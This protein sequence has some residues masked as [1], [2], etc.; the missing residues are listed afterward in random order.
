MFRLSVLA[1]CLALALVGCSDPV[2]QPQPQ[3]EADTGIPSS[4]LLETE[5][6]GVVG[7]AE[8]LQSS[9]VGDEVVVKGWIGGSGSP[10]VAE[11]A[12]MTVVDASVYNK[13]RD[14]ECCET[15]WDYC[16]ATEEAKANMASIRVV[17]ADGQLV[18]KGFEGFGGI[19]ASRQV[20]IR[21]KISTLEAGVLVVDAS[22]VWVAP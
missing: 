18:A 7:I 14:E 13:C 20:T 19:D 3:P 5:P 16:C 15:P 9:A 2:P 6:E 22:G 21:G 12:V 17:A 4:L 1:A 8:V 11:R 10:L